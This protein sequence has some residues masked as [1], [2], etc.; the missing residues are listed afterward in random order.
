MLIA[1]LIFLVIVVVIN[2]KVRNKYNEFVEQYSSELLFSSFAPYS[3]QIIDWIDVQKR[4]PKFSNSYHQKIVNLR[5]SRDAHEHFRVFLSRIV[6]T[7]TFVIILI[8]LMS[9]VSD[10]DSNT[11]MMTSVLGII[12][13]FYQI[14]TLDLRIKKRKDKIL[15]ELPEFTNKVILLVNAGDTVQGAIK[16]CV[17]QN[18]HNIYESPLYFEL[19]EALNNMQSNK[20][21]QDALKE[22]SQRCSLQEV[23]VLTTVIMMNYRK[24]GSMLVDSLQELSKSLWDKRKTITK[25]QGEEASS[26]LIFPIMLIFVTVLVIVLYPALASMAF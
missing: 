4:F 1:S 15:I 2:M 25:I 17:D 12:I 7:L 19:S 22:F 13:V 21:F 26:K 5:G 6:I 9:Y 11:I 10:Y 16:K 23:S 8:G 24:G 20:S 14:R 18:K 3:L